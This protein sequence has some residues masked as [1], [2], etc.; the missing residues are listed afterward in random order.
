MRSRPRTFSKMAR[1]IPMPIGH[2]TDRCVYTKRHNHQNI[3][4][5]KYFCYSKIV[6]HVRQR[7]GVSKFYRYCKRN[8]SLFQDLDG[9][10]SFFVNTC[11]GPVPYWHGSLSEK[12]TY[13]KNLK[14]TILVCTEM[15][16]GYQL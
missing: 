1:T 13:L 7:H 12:L 2:A 11:V 10:V 15:I 8:I 16:Q 9:F 5:K 3:V 6:A 4:I 14:N